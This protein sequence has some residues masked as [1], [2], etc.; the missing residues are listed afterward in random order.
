MLLVI[1]VAYSGDTVSAINRALTIAFDC[2]LFIEH[3]VTKL[4]FSK[5]SIGLKLSQMIK[6][7]LSTKAYN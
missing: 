6:G 5:H 7:G 1:L 3:P 2:K 4:T